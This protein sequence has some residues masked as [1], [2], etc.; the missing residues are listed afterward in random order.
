MELYKAFELFKLNGFN[1]KGDKIDLQAD[2]NET[3]AKNYKSQIDDRAKK[4]YEEF[5][6]LEEAREKAKGDKGPELSLKEKEFNKF[7]DMIKEVETEGKKKAQSVKLDASDHN[8]VEKL[9]KAFNV[10][11]EP[12]RRALSEINSGISSMLEYLKKMSEKL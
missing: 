12:N 11:N 3:I 1:I 5:K 7:K 6:K 2:K 10:I 4:D 8:L 9:S